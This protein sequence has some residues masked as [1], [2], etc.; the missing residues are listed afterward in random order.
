[1]FF[2]AAATGNAPTGGKPI[3]PPPAAPV[4]P[5]PAGGLRGRFPNQ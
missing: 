5:P 4:T 3:A 2:A 1:M